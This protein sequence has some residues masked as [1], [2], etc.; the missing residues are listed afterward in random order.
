MDFDLL[1]ETEHVEEVID[2]FCNVLI[3]LRTGEAYALNVWTLAFF[4]IARRRGEETASRDIA[5]RYLL[6][7]D[8]FVVDLSPATVASVVK[9]MLERGTMPPGCSV[10]DDDGDVPG[11]S[12]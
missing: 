10:N 12:A 2:D 6:P 4:E 9:D 7:P 11:R 8:L 5:N 1:L 3:T